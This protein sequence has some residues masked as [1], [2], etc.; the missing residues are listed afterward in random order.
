M[1][2]MKFTPADE[3]KDELWGP[4]GTPERDAMEAQLK[5]DIQSYFVGEAI[6]KARLKQNLTQEELGER[7]GVKR[8]Q[9]CKLESGK[10]SITLSTMSKV[11]K[12]LGIATATLDLGIGGK[13]ALW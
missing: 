2:K 5:E 7:V 11:F 9:I 1:A 8:S 4:I 12:A 10:S 6:K 3:M 13:V